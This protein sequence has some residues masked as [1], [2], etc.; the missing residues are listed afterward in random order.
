MEDRI[1]IK[2]NRIIIIHQEIQHRLIEKKYPSPLQTHLM[3]D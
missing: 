1:N 2:D 3:K